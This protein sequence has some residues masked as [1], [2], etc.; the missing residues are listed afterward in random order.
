VERQPFRRGA[1]PVVLAHPDDQ[2]PVGVQLAEGVGEAVAHHRVE[3]AD[4]FLD[5]VVDREGGDAVGLEGDRAEAVLGQLGEQLVADPAEGQ[6]QM[7]RLAERQ[8][9]T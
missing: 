8:Q 1:A 3:V 4:A 2:L 5:E 9:L 6:R 7:A